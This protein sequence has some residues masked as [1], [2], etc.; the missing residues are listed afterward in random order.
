[1]KKVFKGLMIAAAVT[2]SAGVCLNAAANTAQLDQLL[3]QVKKNRAADARQVRRTGFSNC[4]R[5]W[6]TADG[7]QGR[8]NA[9][10]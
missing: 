6:Q 10:H 7:R 8:G 2:M 3:E 1:M 4:Q 5:W 9:G